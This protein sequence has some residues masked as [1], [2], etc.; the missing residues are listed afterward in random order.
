MFTHPIGNIQD[1]ET[2]KCVKHK[3]IPTVSTSEG[4]R[5][6]AEAIKTQRNNMTN[7]KIETCIADGEN[8]GNDP[9]NGAIHIEVDTGMSRNG[10]LCDDLPDLVRVSRFTIC[11]LDCSKYCLLI[12]RGR[13]SSV[14]KSSASQAAW[15]PKFKS[16]WG[17]DS[18]H[19]MHE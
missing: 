8:H 19:Q 17:L 5:G 2:E 11:Y 6:M 3:L 4:A 16:W 12:V 1:W 18:S 10:C 14:G 9:P 13:D 15:G 7:T